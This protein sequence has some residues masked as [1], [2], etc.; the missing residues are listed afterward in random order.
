MITTVRDLPQTLSCSTLFKDCRMLFKKAKLLRPLALHYLVAML[1]VLLIAGIMPSISAIFG[2]PGLPASGVVS[3]PL[4]IFL[5]SIFANAYLL[6]EWIR[7][8]SGK[9]T[10]EAAQI[11]K[12]HEA[13]HDPLIGAANRRSFELSP[14]KTTELKQP[15]H[16]LL[17]IDL[18]NFKPV[19]DIYGHA[20][21]DQILFGIT[22][23]IKRLSSAR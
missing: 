22:T 3:S 1:A 5:L 20:A 15:R 17:M 2:G 23:G 19:N 6:R 14:K 4:P 21:G 12:Q 7:T 16:A 10:I 8:L 11:E 13:L 18:D 9:T